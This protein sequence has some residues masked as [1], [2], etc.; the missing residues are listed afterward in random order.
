MKH[1][2]S[3]QFKHQKGFTIVELLIVV[4]VIAILAAI[5]IVSY[6]GITKQANTSGMKSDLSNF[7]KAQE[8]FRIEKGAAFSDTDE[9]KEAGAGALSD[10]STWLPED[11]YPGGTD[12]STNTP[13]GEYL[14]Q[15]YESSTGPTWFNGEYYDALNIEHF[16]VVYWDYENGHWAVRNTTWFGNVEKSEST[17]TNYRNISDNSS[18]CTAATFEGCYKEMISD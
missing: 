8:V 9:M 10:K 2:N 14:L 5:T 3:R 6:N 13:R 16:D 1:I 4:V 11:E 17:D 18:P 7:A 15:H 12:L